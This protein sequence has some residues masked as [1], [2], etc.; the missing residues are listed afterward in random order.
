[1]V[2]VSAYRLCNPIERVPVRRLRVPCGQS[3]C[4]AQKIIS[5]LDRLRSHQR[6]VPV[7]RSPRKDDVCGARVFADKDLGRIKSKGGGQ[8][9]G[10]AAPMGK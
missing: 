5:V 2:M 6:S 9:H 7:M 3:L 4:G 1:M 8:A 10:L